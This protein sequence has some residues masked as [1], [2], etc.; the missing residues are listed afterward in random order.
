MISP[1]TL[2]MRHDCSLSR[3]LRL[4]HLLT[5]KVSVFYLWYLYFRPKLLLLL[6]L[7]LLLAAAAAAAVV[8]VSFVVYLT[9]L[10]ASQRMTRWLA[11]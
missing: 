2:M 10:S 6:L 11:E 3:P 7:L 1:R 9:T 4:N 5:N 8:V